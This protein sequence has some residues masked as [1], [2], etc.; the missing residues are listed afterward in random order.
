MSDTMLLGV[1]RMPM[2]ENPDP[3]T[4]RQ[5]VDRARQ[6]AD[7]IE[8]DTERIA[9]LEREVE[10]ERMRL[11]AVAVVAAA[12]TPE[13]AASA[14]AIHEDYRGATLETV[15]RRVD[16][17]IALREALKQVREAL[18]H[19]NNVYSGD[20]DLVINALSAIEKVQP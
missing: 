18:E 12:D 8:A 9:A 17:C 11:V 15:I 6:A 3:L 10:T 1:L 13:S 2:P 4:L 7:R 20:S 14:R 19:L 16:E 5:F